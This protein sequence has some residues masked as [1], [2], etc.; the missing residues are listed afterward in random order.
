MPHHEVVTLTGIVRNV[1]AHR[2]TLEAD[3]K[4]YLAD[5]GP[6]GAEIF[7]LSE[8]LEISLKGEQRPSELKVI[9]IAAKG[10]T[11]VALHHE[12]PHHRPGHHAGRHPAPH[13]ADPKLA[14]RSAEIAGWKPTGM[15]QRKPHHF[16]VL[17]RQGNGPWAELHIDLDGSLYKVKALPPGGGKWAQLIS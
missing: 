6:K 2:F 13:D 3:G 17:A 12:K 8:K 5:L 1:F 9:E 14:V 4:V 15:P 10:K 7:S 11:L 16:E